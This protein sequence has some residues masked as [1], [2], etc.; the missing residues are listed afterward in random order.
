M[1]YKDLWESKEKTYK[2][3]EKDVYIK[4]STKEEAP[5]EEV[6]DKKA[7]A[8]KDAGKGKVEEPPKP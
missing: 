5:V 4:I 7:P 3:D 2:V 8:A 6:K 1:I